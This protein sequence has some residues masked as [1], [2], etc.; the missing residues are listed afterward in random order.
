M[1]LVTL[2]LTLLAGSLFTVP[3]T[4]LQYDRAAVDAGDV[5]RLVTCQWTHWSADH[6]LWDVVVFAMLGGVCERENRGSLALTIVGA[7]LLVPL[8]VH[9]GCPGI[10]SF[11][12]LSGIDSALLGLLLAAL[13]IRARSA[14]A[15]HGQLIA[16]GGVIAFS[17]KCS[18]E[19]ATASPIFAQPDATWQ[20]VPLSHVVGFL[21]GLT[22]PL[23]RA[24]SRCA[25]LHAAPAQGAPARSASRMRESSLAI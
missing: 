3:A 7:N 25:T 12:G 10:T 23:V 14:S 18:I 24:G 20:V 17:V 21:C 22:V 4:A 6:L 1:P 9:L 8:A 11:R 2:I 13:F 5:W 19:C 15:L 16:A